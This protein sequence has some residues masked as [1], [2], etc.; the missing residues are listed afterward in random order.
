MRVALA[1]GI[2]VAALTAAGCGGS[3]GSAEAE[4]WASDVCTDIAAWQSRVE[5]I[6]KNA[7]QA[8]SSQSASRSQLRRAIE[9]GLRASRKFVGELRAAGPPPVERG[10]EAQRKLESLARR[11]QGSVDDVQKALDALPPNA[12]VTEIVTRAVGLA[13]ALQAALGAARATIESMTGLGG[14]LKRGFEDAESCR[15]LRQ[16][17]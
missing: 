11:V 15:Q 1:T 5:T 12:T 2:A 14:D 9:R 7:A 10:A 17:S 8:L 16:Q 13:G 3:G 6:A 4:A